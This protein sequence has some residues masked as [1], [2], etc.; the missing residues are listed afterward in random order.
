M[1]TARAANR[2]KEIGV[3]KVNGALRWDV[4]VQFMSEALL[5]TTAAAAIACIAIVLLLPAYNNFLGK[6]ISL[7]SFPMLVMP[8]IVVVGFISGAY[9]ALLFSSF[10]PID[11]L[12]GKFTAS[13]NSGLR[14]T[15][16]VF[17][18]VV[19]G[20]LIFSTLVVWKQMAFIKT[21]DLGFNHDHT[22]TVR[23]RDKALYEKTPELREMLLRNP[24]IHKVSASNRP[25][26]GISSQQGR[27]WQGKNGVQHISIYINSIDPHF[28][29]LYEIPLLAG[30]NFS[31]TSW[32]KDIVVN[33][34]LVKELGFT[35]DEIIGRS[36]IS[37]DTA[38]VI[39]VVADFHYMDMKL[40]ILPMEFRTFEWSNPQF[41]SIKIQEDDVPAV[42]EF[43]RKT[44]T[45][46]SEK[47]PFEYSFYDEVYSKTFMAEAKTS[48]LM[49]VFS[50]VAIVIAALGLY[51]L[52]LHMVNQRMKE[53]GI[54]K[55]LGAGSWSIVKLL[56]GRF[57][58]LI[59]VGYAISCGVGYYGIEKWLQGFAY[60][61]SPGTTDFVMTLG[62]IFLIAAVAVLSRIMMALRINPARVLKQE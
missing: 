2:A 43:I 15:L 52:I 31:A 5:S 19:S 24:A 9:P 23:L 55:T 48:K 49:T 51:G 54:R 39:G 7:D 18:F 30:Q 53:I 60:R 11:T 46:I 22:I 3:R 13:R 35:N 21:K 34:T 59:L 56:S 33:E 28:I 27:K 32:K 37:R 45:G 4:I 36:F 6:E 38:R 25:A 10:K 12:K 62:A 41:L 58:L 40:K 26:T 50:I 47:Y 8:L 29:D 14:N 61:V 44:L 20:T 1:S 57:G 16:V 42:L 17:Q